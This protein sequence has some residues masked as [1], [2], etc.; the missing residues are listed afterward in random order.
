MEELKPC[1]KCGGKPN[2]VLGYD[3]EYV[4][5]E[6]CKCKT[7][8]EFGDYYDEGYMDGLYVI[9]KWNAGVVI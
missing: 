2:L 8:T 5:C 7:E 6:K 3:F 4:I 1:P 9:P